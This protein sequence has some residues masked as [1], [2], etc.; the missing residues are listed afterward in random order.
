M[1]N[2]TEAVVDGKMEPINKQPETQQLLV[3]GQYLYHEFVEADDSQKTRM[4][5][6]R[7]L[8][9][10]G[11]DPLQIKG[12][13]DEMVKLAI[14]KDVANGVD[15]KVRGPKRATAM[16]VRTIV[17]NV[18]GALK[19]APDALTKEGFN[20]NTGWLEG[21]VMA[22]KALATGGKV[23]NGYDVPTQEQKEQAALQ[24]ARAGE[25]E[26]ML[27]ATKENPRKPNES[28][29]G[30]NTRI[31]QAAESLVV[32]AQ[33]EKLETDAKKLFEYA[34]KKYDRA[35][36]AQAMILFHDY[37]QSE[38]AGESEVSEE[39][40]NAMLAQAAE[41]GDVVVSENEHVEA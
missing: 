17:Q 6:I 14:K 2:A 27:Q 32:K 40:A 29:L 18:Y 13:T 41:S 15:E 22:K 10:K 11:A 37:F 31:G 1:S 38:N 20:E 24:R 16:N 7:D 23:W 30:W 34:V 19:F 12:A 26:A 8:V 3:T 21:A 39:E 9:A 5:L 35:V 33:Q 25:T 36:I 4:N 28:L